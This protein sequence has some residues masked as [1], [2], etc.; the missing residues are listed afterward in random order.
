MKSGVCVS[1][2]VILPFVLVFWIPES[3]S[4][5]LFRRF[6]DEPDRS[7]MV[8]GSRSQLPNPANEINARNYG[9]VPV[10]SDIIRAEVSGTI[11][12]R[13]MPDF[14]SQPS[15]AAV[16]PADRPQL[17]MV[18]RPNWFTGGTKVTP[19]KSRFPKTIGAADDVKS[20]K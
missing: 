1:V 2:F 7:P 9:P 8:N 15:L 13:P 16:S 14:T 6:F 4:G 19:P 3:A 18:L 5:Q 11:L 10:V 12:P 17:Q 20:I